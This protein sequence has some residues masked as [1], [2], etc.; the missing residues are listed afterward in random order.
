MRRFARVAC[1]SAVLMASIVLGTPTSSA[2]TSPLDAST[3]TFSGS[4]DGTVK[5]TRKVSVPAGGGLG[6]Y[7]KNTDSS[8]D[9]FH[10]R[11]EFDIYSD[12]G[13]NV[14]DQFVT[15]YLNMGEVINQ[16]VPVSNAHSYY[17]RVE[18]KVIIG[19]GYDGCDGTFTISS[20]A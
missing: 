8:A 12:D 6:V 14:T 3:I 18:C 16:R 13:R 20:W 5:T 19:I 17:I 11:L 10:T 4:P 15:D 9:L 2:A 1:S 7:G